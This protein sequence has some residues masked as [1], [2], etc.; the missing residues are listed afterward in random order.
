MQYNLLVRN[1]ELEVTEVCKREG[2][3]L[4]PWSPLKGKGFYDGT[5]V[6]QN[7]LS[8]LLKIIKLKKTSRDVIHGHEI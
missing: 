7:K 6:S 1:I 5:V 4:L 3:G 8:L 2:L